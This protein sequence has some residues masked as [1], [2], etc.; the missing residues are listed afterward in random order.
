MSGND[1]GD[2][3]EKWKIDLIE[4][5]ARSLGFT[6]DEIPDLQQD[7][8]LHLLGFEYDET[9]GANETTLPVHLSRQKQS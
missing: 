6:R 5:R 2:L 8:V 9:Q 4:M 7:I 1:Y 3:I